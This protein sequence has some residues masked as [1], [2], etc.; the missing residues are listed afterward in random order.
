MAFSRTLMTKSIT[1]PACQHMASTDRLLESILHALVNFVNTRQL[2]RS[3]D[4]VFDNVLDPSF[5]ARCG[6]PVL[7]RKL[8]AEE[9]LAHKKQI[10]AT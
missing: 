6:P 1:L 5:S 10:I 3:T 9:Y 8:G 4:T 2:D 7:P